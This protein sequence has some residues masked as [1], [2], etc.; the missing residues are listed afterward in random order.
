MMRALA[1]LL[2]LFA[3]SPLPYRPEGRAASTGRGVQ[4]AQGRRRLP[5]RAVRRRADAHQPDDHRRRPQGPR[6]GRAR[7]STTGGRTSTGRSSARR[8][9]ASSSSRTPTAT[10]RRTRRPRSTRRRRSSPRSASP[11]RQ[12]PDGKGYKVFVCQSP[13]IL[14]FE[15][16]DGDLQ[17]RRPAEEAP[18]RLPRLRPRPRR[19]RHHHRPG[20]QALLHRRR[21]GRRRA[22]K[23]SDGK[24][25][26]WTSN[27][28]DCRAGTVW[29]CD[30]DGKN[31]ELIA[32]NF[33]NNYECCV[34]SFGERLALAT[35]TTTATSRRASAT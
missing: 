22:C 23:S 2:L 28:T 16:K 33:R 7:R 34:D 13:D 3:L 19:P 35:T 24:G 9:T 29:R 21:R 12:D 26:K 6:L 27:N 4:G 14:V 25:T 11:S 31:L 10:A 30:L 18:H 32:H 15:D 17:G 1:A 20:R 5:G 8:A